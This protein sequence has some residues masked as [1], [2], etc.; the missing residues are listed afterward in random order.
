LVFGGRAKLKDKEIRGKALKIE[1]AK[2]R[3][4]GIRKDQYAENNTIND[5]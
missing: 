5:K 1:E 3:S 4:W 2:I